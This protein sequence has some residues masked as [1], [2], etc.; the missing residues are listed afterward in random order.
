MRATR[1]RLG[2]EAIT[3]EQL[4]R[5]SLTVFNSECFVNKPFVRELGEHR[6]DHVHSSVQDD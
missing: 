6:R 3:T 2:H 4:H 1:H 5:T